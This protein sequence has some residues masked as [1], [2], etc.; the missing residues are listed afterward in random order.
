MMADYERRCGRVATCGLAGGHSGSCVFQAIPVS[1][2]WLTNRDVLQAKHMLVDAMERYGDACESRRG[3]RVD[4]AREHYQ[5]AL[6]NLLAR[7]LEHAQAEAVRKA[8]LRP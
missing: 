5:V 7:V 1:V 6:E 2:D 3:S 4:A 8:G